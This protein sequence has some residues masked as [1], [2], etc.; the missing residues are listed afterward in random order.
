MAPSAVKKSRLDI[1]CFTPMSRTAWARSANSAC[2]LSGAPNSFTSMA[3]A[4][5]NRSVIR[6]P[7]SAF[8]AIAWRR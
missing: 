7:S 1:A 2:S 5:L 3:P 6:L 4:T 8:R